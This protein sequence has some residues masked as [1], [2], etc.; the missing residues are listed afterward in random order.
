MRQSP[1][2]SKQN[3]LINIFERFNFVLDEFSRDLAAKQNNIIQFTDTYNI[4]YYVCG[5]GTF[6]PKKQ[7]SL[8]FI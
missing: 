4:Y 1:N 6:E 7:I 3:K 5:G 8:S 2:Y